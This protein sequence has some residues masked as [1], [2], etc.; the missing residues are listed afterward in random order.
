M[1]WLLSVVLLVLSLGAVA[2]RSD[3]VLVRGDLIDIREAGPKKEF[4]PQN[5]GSACGNAL[6]AGTKFAVSLMEYRG[7]EKVCC[8]KDAKCRI[9]LDYDGRLPKPWVRTGEVFQV[10]GIDYYVYENPRIKTGVWTDIPYPDECTHSAVVFG[11]SISVDGVPEFGT[12]IAKVPILRKGGAYNQTITMLPDGSYLAACTGIGKGPAMFRS[13]DKGATWERFGSYDVK[14]NLVSNYHNLFTLGDKVYFMGVGPDREGLRISCSSDG[15]MTWSSPVDSHSGLILEGKYHTAPVPMLVSGGRI[16][17]ACETYED[18]SPFV[19]SAPIGSDLLEAS[20]WTRTNTV[21]KGALSIMGYRMTGSLIEGNIVEARD[22]E[23]I[24]LIRT[25]STQTSRFATMLHVKGID[26]LYF[27]PS[28]DW[29][30]MPGG[31]KKFTVRFDP[32]SEMYWALTNPD[33]TCDYSHQG[34]YVKGMSHSLIRNRLVLVCSS[35]LVKWIEVG[36]VLYDPDPFF[37]GFQY[38]DWVFDGEDIAAVVRVAA[39]ESRGLP[40]RQHDSNMMSFVKIENFR[41]MLIEKVLQM[42]DSLPVSSGT[43]TAQLRRQIMANPAEWEVAA[44]FLQRQDLMGIPTGRYNLSESGTYANVQEYVTKE[45]FKYEAHRKYIDVQVVLSGKELIKVA[46]LSEV[47]EPI[48]PYNPKKDIEFHASAVSSR[49]LLA[50]PGH[51]VI[52]F[53]SD[54]H[55]PCISFD[56]PSDIRKVVVKIPY[57]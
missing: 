5:N 16:W 29:V 20:S 30:E 46:P 48:K 22:G 56:A 9:A 42:W 49:S 1:R 15:G 28:C 11:D 54:A 51:W 57:K 18:K 53:P 2:Q 44:E 21:G 23:V 7:P 8:G 47:R 33:D 19:V 14:K 12:V 38:A 32:V 25:N 6:P 34:I 52:L 13:V 39:P 35:D 27:D 40:T 17:R 3:E 31:G 50:D 43:D 26:S 41:N 36:T 10:A 4:F 37:H 45:S 24:N 55:A